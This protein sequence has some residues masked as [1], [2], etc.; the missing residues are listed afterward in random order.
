VE[1]VPHGS[2]RGYKF[3]WF[4]VAH[5][6]HLHWQVEPHAPRDERVRSASHHVEHLG[7]ESHLMQWDGP[8][9]SEYR[10]RGKIDPHVHTGVRIPMQAQ[11]ALPRNN[12]NNKATFIEPPMNALEKSSLLAISADMEVS[13]GLRSGFLS[14]GWRFDVRCARRRGRAWGAD[15]GR[16]RCD[17]RLVVD[18]PSI[19]V[20]LRILDQHEATQRLGTG[21]YGKTSPMV[22]ESTSKVGD[23]QPNQR[24]SS[25]CCP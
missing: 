18:L 20:Q 2:I 1:A 9:R 13:D 3:G 17:S 6:F 25:W 12:S 16:G 23:A 14:G 7:V 5:G 4:F 24:T 10:L 21:S 15:R 11:V 22:R 8:F 19:R